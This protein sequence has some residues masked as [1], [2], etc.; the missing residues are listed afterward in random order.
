MTLTT[1]INTA[2]II[3]E[4][5]LAH[6]GPDPDPTFGPVVYDD[7]GL[8]QDYCIADAI[9][10]DQRTRTESAEPD[11]ESLRLLMLLVD[12]TGDVDEAEVN[13][14]VKLAWGKAADRELNRV[15]GSDESPVVETFN[16]AE[17]LGVETEGYTALLNEP[18]TLMLGS[19]YGAKD[20]RN[21][22]DGDWLPVTQ[23]WAQWLIGGPGDKKNAP[24]GFTR[25]PVNKAKEGACVVLGSSIGK[26]R[27]ANAMQT[28][29]AMGLDIDSGASLDSMLDKV[30][31]LGLFCIVYTTHSHGK[32]LPPLPRDTVIQKLKI[33]PEE[34]DDSKVREYLR[35]H[36]K[37]RYEESFIAGVK[38]TDARKETK[39]GEVIEVSSPML[40]K[41]RLIFPLA[42]PVHI[43]DLAQT[44]GA[45]LDVWEDKITG[46][47]RETLGVHF[48]TSCT[49]PSRLFFTARHPKDAADWYCAVVRGEP[50]RF[51]DVPTVKKSTYLNT[52]KPMNAFDMAGGAADAGDRPAQAFAPSGASLND[53]HSKAKD[54]F[55]MANLLEDLC[56][57]RIRRAGN[58]AQGQVHIEC[59]F[60][61]EHSSE[62]GTACDARNAL[63][64]SSGFWTWG[65]HHD[66]C[67]GRHK[68]AFLEEALRL[69]WF[70]EDQ[71]FGDSV[72]MMGGVDED[73]EDDDSDVI[74]ADAPADGGKVSAAVLQKRFRK[75][76]R[77]GA[78]KADKADAI[79]DAV[80]ESG[81][82]KRE[83]SGFWDEEDRAV[84]QKPKGRST[85]PE[86]SITA[87]YH[88]QVAY[89]QKRIVAANADAPR[90]FAY[91][92]SFAVVDERKGRV[93]LLEKQSALFAEVHKVTRWEKVVDDKG[94]TRLVS[95][96]EDVVRFI[97]EES[98]FKDTLPE[99]VGGV[100]TTP[101]FAADGSLVI[102][103]GYHAGAQVFLA[104]TPGLVVPRVSGKPTAEEV[105][106]AKRLLIDD[107]LADFPLGGMTRAQIIAAE[108]A[109]NAP[110]A[111]T[112]AYMLLPFCRA[113]IAGPT[114]GHVFT[115]PAPG[116]GAS[117]LDDMCAMIDAAKPAPARVPKSGDE[118]GKVLTSVLK[119]G[120]RRVR[121][122][123]AHDAI[124]SDDLASAMTAENY[125]ARV[126]G[127][128]QAVDVA[129]RAVWGFTAN[130]FEASKEILR[131]L[132]FIPLDAGE[133]DP[134]NR[135]PAGGW[136]HKNLR[137]WVAEHRG[138]LVWACLTLIQ[139]WVAQG[140][141]KQTTVTKGS[142]EVWAG[143][144]GGVLDAAG[145]EGFLLGQEEE[146]E[147]ARDSAQDAM[148]HFIDVVADYKPGTYFRAGSTA[149]FGEVNTVSLQAVLNGNVRAGNDHARAEPILVRGMGYDRVSGQYESSGWIGKCM[150]TIS[151]KPWVSGDKELTF[152]TLDDT[153]NKTVVY[154]LDVKVRAA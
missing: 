20:R 17:L 94:N 140:A 126:L 113:M 136:R 153:K 6:I 26:A 92:D 142:Y 28:M 43:R 121:F 137:A 139:N 111:H 83:V 38:I 9:L 77:D 85:I 16:D 124:A 23:P 108:G 78:S 2:T 59:P 89:A 143:V 52:R 4:S 82:G 100:V 101:F 12:P 57:D 35:L 32:T 106:K 47:A 88:E 73:E 105:E 135:T 133:A 128:S 21:T 104:P 154:R 41:Y 72:Y 114:P 86:K 25:H 87:D 118:M 144:I 134:E 98:T 71:L 117:L 30:E 50:L 102:E 96:P 80:K 27:K 149:P 115:K 152:T 62:G 90:I 34:L 95:P 107:V 13:R 61:S 1:E 84:N 56:A 19:L 64:S 37:N 8:V 150:R 49:D 132:V 65:C 91:M 68:L 63:D 14:L 79:R 55:N 70:D 60:E 119:D 3:I 148:Q 110:V 10:A 44:R 33:K 29:Y 7:D 39:T 31:D 74:E 11:A 76:I 5:M 138:E 116:T 130:N 24:W 48:D 69:N 122:D 129:V 112:L 40:D 97:Y 146:Q 51:E 75:M 120:P 36:D 18:A 103:P 58:E 67:R 131:R 99:L 93:R 147:K 151:R 15:S 109:A 125:G 123:N 53:W 81:F 127:R 145:I 141:V 54:R 22:Q 42:I 66:S 46:L 45:A